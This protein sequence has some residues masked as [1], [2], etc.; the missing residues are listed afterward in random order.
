MKK[1]YGELKLGGS[2]QNF[3]LFRSRAL[4]E[5]GK[6]FIYVSANFYIF[7]EKKE[8]SKKKAGPTKDPLFGSLAIITCGP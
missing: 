7:A 8:R 2:L 6:V 5:F 1:I 4:R 3:T